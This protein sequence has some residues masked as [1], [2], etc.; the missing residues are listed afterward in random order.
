M[1]EYTINHNKKI[2]GIWANGQIPV[3]IGKN[4]PK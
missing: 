4:I 1:L 3:V 2:L